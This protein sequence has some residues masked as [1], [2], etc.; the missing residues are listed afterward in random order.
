VRWLILVAIAC[1]DP[2]PPSADGVGREVPTPVV[3]RQPRVDDRMYDARGVPLPSDERV[4]GLTLPR[5]LT[6]QPALSSERRHVYH[7]T[8]P[9]APLLRYFGPRLTTVNIQERGEAVTYVDAVP[10]EARGGIVRL[11]V[12]ILPSSAHGARVEIYE[13]PPPREG[14]QVSEEAIRRHLDSLTKNRE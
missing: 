13:R 2:V 6:K 7:S 14:V 10:R 12:S 1:S 8:V 9:R 11:D 3:E 5:G 4:A